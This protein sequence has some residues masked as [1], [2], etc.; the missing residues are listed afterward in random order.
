MNVNRSNYYAYVKAQAI[1]AEKPQE[2]VETALKNLFDQH[3]E[4]YGSRRLLAQ[5]KM[6]GFKVGRYRVRTLMKKHDLVVKQKLRFKKTTWIPLG[7]KIPCEIKSL[8][9]NLATL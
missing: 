1:K 6:D 3:K 8:R 7:Q 9:D 2:E 4:N 5:L